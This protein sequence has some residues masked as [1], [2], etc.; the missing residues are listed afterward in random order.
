MSCVHRNL[1]S[2][3][4]YFAI[5]A[6]YID[7]LLQWLVHVAVTA[8]MWWSALPAKLLL[9]DILYKVAPPT[10]LF[11][12]YLRKSPPLSDVHRMAHMDFGDDFLDKAPEVLPQLEGS[13]VPFPHAHAFA[14][15]LHALFSAPLGTVGAMA[16]IIAAC[17][18]AQTKL[19][20]CTLGF[21]I[22]MNI[23]KAWMLAG[24]VVQ[25]PWGVRPFLWPWQLLVC[26]CAC[27]FRFQEYAYAARAL[28]VWIFGT[29]QELLLGPDRHA[30]C[31]F[32]CARNQPGAT[33]AADPN[34][35]K[36]LPVCQSLTALRLRRDWTSV[37]RCWDRCMIGFYGVDL[38]SL[39]RILKDGFRP[40]FNEAYG[41]CVLFASNVDVA[42]NFSSEGWVVIACLNAAAVM[43]GTTTAKGARE[44]LVVAVHDPSKDASIIGVLCTTLAGRLLAPS[45]LPRSWL[46]QMYYEHCVKLRETALLGPTSP[47]G[48][49]VA[50]YNVH[51]WRDLDGKRGFRAIMQVIDH[52]G[53]DVLLLN[54]VML[55]WTFVTRCRFENAM[56]KAGYTDFVYG[57]AIR[58]LWRSSSLQAV[59]AA[60]S[61]AMRVAPFFGNV[62]CSKH[63]ISDSKVKWMKGYSWPEGRSIV[64][65]TIQHPSFAELR[66]SGTHFD[67][68]DRTG[69]TALTQCHQLLAMASCEGFA[70]VCGDLNSFRREEYTP[71]RLGRFPEPH[72]FPVTAAL[73]SLG[74]VDC[75][76]ACGQPPP[77][78]TAWSTARVDYMYASPALAKYLRR[79]RVFPSSASDHFPLLVNC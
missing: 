72:H 16:G 20:K 51:M 26:L 10:R 46:R 1:A 6:C 64:A 45:M 2:S 77:E 57:Q 22:V 30:Y 8:H 58:G 29:W 78:M 73:E 14:I 27:T 47:D 62:L 31:S 42:A 28:Q 37:G 18:A 7:S 5:G 75:F 9:V 25:W 39:Q 59:N 79:P 23:A 17:W 71:E 40:T 52:L 49:C 24:V 15:V 68:W 53:A 34:D 4:L 13:W 21:G 60:H 69:E 33:K 63:H 36:W 19:L 54:E 55:T 61:C 48:L 50:T 38:D 35:A 76:E 32:H 12:Y 67:I 65:G 44:A 70:L 66:V 3:V 41:H 56:R 74:W 11:D 43:A